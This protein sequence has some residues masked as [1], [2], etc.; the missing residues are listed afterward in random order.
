MV[1]VIKLVYLIL[2]A[3]KT[4]QPSERKQGF[5]L[6]QYPLTIL[7]SNILYIYHFLNII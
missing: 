3:V 5:P 7:I 1:F 6:N 2:L 4:N